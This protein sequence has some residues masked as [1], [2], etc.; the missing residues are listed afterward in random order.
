MSTVF[1]VCAIAGGAI[2]LVQTAL[3]LVGLG[4]HALGLDLHTDAHGDAG[5]ALNL[6]S[7]R[8]IA[9]GLAFFGLAGLLV[10]S[11]GLGMVLGAVAGILAGLAAAVAMAFAMRGLARLEDDGSLRMQGAV[12]QQGTVYLGIPGGRS[13]PGK[14]HLSL[15]GRTVE[16]QAIAEHPLVTGSPVVV[17][18]VLG[19]DTVLVAPQTEIGGLIDAPR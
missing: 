15:Q 9:A 3:S 14:V 17:V 4:D 19:P 6:L 11:L 8:A 2:L 13:A 10:E 16:C 1:L 5:D 12:G 18:D 7:L